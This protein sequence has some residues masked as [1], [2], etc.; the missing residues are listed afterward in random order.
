[1]KPGAGSTSTSAKPAAAGESAEHAEAIRLADIRRALE[2]ADPNA[3]RLA[4]Y[5][6]NRR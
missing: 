5:Q 6:G 4:L 3:L 1:M 2:Q